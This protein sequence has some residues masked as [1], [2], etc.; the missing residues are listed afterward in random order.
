LNDHEDWGW[1]RDELVPLI[2]A[3]SSWSELLTTFFARSEVDGHPTRWLE[4]T[5]GNVFGYAQARGAFPDARFIHTMRDGRDVV[6]SLTA[7]GHSAFRAATRWYCGT[8]AGLALGD[9]PDVI[10]VS[11]EALVRDPSHQMEAVLSRLGESYDA[12]VLET[13]QNASPL[14]PSWRNA[15][16]GAV[17]D[18]SIGRLLHTEVEAVTAVLSA[19][20]LSDDGYELLNHARLA[21]AESE[22]WPSVPDAIDLLALMG[23]ECPRGRPLRS[24][25]RSAIRTDLDE[26][27]AAQRSQYVIARSCLPTAI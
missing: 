2:N 13:D 4:K 27:Q 8:L 22:V 19:I 5:P 18:R 14:I 21:S 23:Y 1:R 15:E 17:T 24:S 12:A 26:F 25:E 6:A 20:R 9:H 11:Y 3:S 7:R 16:Y 10:H